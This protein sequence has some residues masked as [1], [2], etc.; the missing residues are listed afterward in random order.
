MAETLP[1]YQQPTPAERVAE[2]LGFVKRMTG[3][4]EETRL[5]VTC[6]A[7]EALGCAAFLI[8]ETI[9][10]VSAEDPNRPQPI[11]HTASNPFVFDE[12]N[13]KHESLHKVK[14]ELRHSKGKRIAVFMVANTVKGIL[15]DGDISDV[16]RL[17]FRAVNQ[18]DT[19]A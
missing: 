11:D 17:V 12:F 7:P 14:I 19:A 13:V 16:N 1:S 4:G 6:S 15:E 5:D 18:E 9:T 2:Q 8:D 3:F 10:S